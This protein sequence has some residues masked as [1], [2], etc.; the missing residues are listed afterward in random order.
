MELKT[1]NRIKLWRWRRM[2]EKDWPF[3]DLSS[4]EEEGEAPAGGMGVKGRR[5]VCRE[6]DRPVTSCL[7]DAFPDEPIRLKS[8]GVVLILQHPL[9]KRRKLAT[10]PLLRKSL[11]RCEVLVGRD[12]RRPGR[13]PELD[14]V[15]SLAEAGERE[16]DLPL[17]EIILW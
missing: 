3:R 14:R 4:D 17:R 15:M 2:E 9:E 13:F 6:C 5:R 16:R 8:G 10:V 11:E 7:C 1:F 12:F